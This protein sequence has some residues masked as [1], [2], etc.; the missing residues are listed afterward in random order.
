ML[1]ETAIKYYHMGYNC[2]ESII[3]AGNEVYDLGLHDKDMI[4]TAA[5]GGGFQIGDVCGALSGAACV[6]SSRYVETKAHDCAYLRPLTQKLVIAFQR[7][8]GSRLCAQIKPVFHSK[9][10]KCERTVEVAASVLEE[11]IKEWDEEQKKAG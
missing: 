7:R 1:S 8:M 10:K 2:A 4:M 11:V 3:R 9:E 6:I 5:F